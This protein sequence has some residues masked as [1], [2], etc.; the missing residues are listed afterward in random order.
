MV[1]MTTCLLRGLKLKG[2]FLSASLT[3]STK[4]TFTVSSRF[5]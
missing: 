5:V 3:N 4:N 2:F 1:C